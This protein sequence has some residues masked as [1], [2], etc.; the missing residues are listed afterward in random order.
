MEIVAFDTDDR[1]DG[2]T[3]INN[4]KAKITWISKGL[5]LTEHKMNSTNTT[6]GGWESSEMRSYLKNTIK[7]LIPETVRNAIVPVTKVQS[8]YGS[9]FVVNGQ[10]T[11]DDVWIPSNHEVDSTSI[12]YESTV[13]TYSLKFTSNETRVKKQET[14]R[15]WWWLRSTHDASHFC[16]VNG[17][18]RMM[19]DDA[20]YANRLTLGFCT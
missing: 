2:D 1:A 13:A 19:T 4:G 5:L 17:D 8:I 3:T 18:G 7:P 16:T 12:G 15:R 10:T 14:T 11:T 9:K 20:N 6:A